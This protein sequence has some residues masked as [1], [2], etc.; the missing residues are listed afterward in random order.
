MATNVCTILL[1]AYSPECHLVAMD[2]CLQDQRNFEN[3]STIRRRVYAQPLQAGWGSLLS[4]RGRAGYAVTLYGDAFERRYFEGML[5]LHRHPTVNDGIYGELTTKPLPEVVDLPLERRFAE[6]DAAVGRAPYRQRT[7]YVALFGDYAEP[8][9]REWLEQSLGAVADAGWRAALAHGLG[10]EFVLA[11]D[12]EALA[13]L[14]AGGALSAVVASFNQFRDVLQAQG[15]AVAG[16]TRGALIVPGGAQGG[17]ELVNDTIGGNAWFLWG[18]PGEAEV[19]EALVAF[20]RHACAKAHFRDLLECAGL[21]AT[22]VEEQG[23][24]AR[25]GTCRPMVLLEPPNEVERDAE[26]TRELRWSVPWAEAFPEITGGTAPTFAVHPGED[27]IA[28]RAAA[29]RVTWHGLDIYGTAEIACSW[30]GELDRRRFEVACV[31]STRAS[32]ASHVRVAKKWLDAKWAM[33]TEEN[34]ALS[35]VAIFAGSTVCVEPIW[36]NPHGERLPDAGMRW[37]VTARTPGAH[38][39]PPKVSYAS[40]LLTLKIPEADLYDVTLTHRGRTLQFV[41]HVYPPPVGVDVALS[42]EDGQ[43]RISGGGD[44]WCVRLCPGRSLRIRPRYRYEPANPEGFAEVVERFP[45]LNFT[46]IP[47]A[48]PKPFVPEKMPG[49]LVEEEETGDWVF[50]APQQAIGR[51]PI[52]FGMHDISSLALEL[53]THDACKD[54]MITIKM[55][56]DWTLRLALGSVVATLVCVLCFRF[57]DYGL[58]NA[59]STVYLVA[60]GAQGILFLTRFCVNRARVVQLLG[61]LVILW[62]FLS[63]LWQEM[64]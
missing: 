24:L 7:V 46:A 1:D 23:R 8:A 38:R 18:V 52:A 4:A 61:A 64:L 36:I 59:R 60:G 34:G 39:A 10:V 15:V 42:S 31:S 17:A 44:A 9:R 41:L 3:L 12:V 47:A 25:L 45:H 22:T 51:T 50:T 11:K 28:V 49:E 53:S 13:A 57:G 37:E 55:V 62:L 2:G 27:S 43:T 21:P 56:T 32:A 35:G 54:T 30:N 14:S 40:G 63:E 6:L 33:T 5:R 48:L 26:C 16:G 20:L 19:P 58:D 29:N